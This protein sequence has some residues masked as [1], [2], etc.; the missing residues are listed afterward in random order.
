MEPGNSI[1]V[2]EII[3]ECNGKF[4]VY[5]S[6]DLAEDVSDYELIAEFSTHEKAEAFLKDGDEEPPF[7]PGPIGFVD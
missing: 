6:P 2:T 4:L 1:D 3:E 7:H 5:R